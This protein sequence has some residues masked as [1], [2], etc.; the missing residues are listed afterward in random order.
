MSGQPCFNRVLALALLN[1]HVFILPPTHSYITKRDTAVTKPSRKVI[2]ANARREA[3]SSINPTFV[4]AIATN[5]AFSAHTVYLDCTCDSNQHFMLS[6]PLKSNV[7]PIMATI[8]I[9][10]RSCGRKIEIKSSSRE[11]AIIPP[12]IWSMKPLPRISKLLLESLTISRTIMPGSP[13]V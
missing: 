7:R 13:R 9:A 10:E 11:N 4:A 8:L 12:T 1:R 6:L 2:Q 5:T 3:P